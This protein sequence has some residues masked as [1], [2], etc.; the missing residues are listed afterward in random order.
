VKDLGV[1]RARG[2]SLMP[3]R[4]CESRERRNVYQV[5]P[6]KFL[7]VVPLRKEI[8]TDIRKYVYKDD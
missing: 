2:G 8:E 6:L 1:K 4:A 3:R 5:Q 7:S